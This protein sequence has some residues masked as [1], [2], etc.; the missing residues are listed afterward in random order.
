M[1][2]ALVALVLVPLGAEPAAAAQLVFTPSADAW[3]DSGQPA[4]SLGT[5]SSLWVDASPDTEQSFLRFEVAGIAGATVTDVRLRLYRKDASGPGGTV[6]LASGAWNETVT[7]NTRPQVSTALAPLSASVPQG[8]W[9]E[10]SLGPVISRDGTLDLA[11][12]TT[13]TDGAQWGAREGAFDPQLIVET[14][15]TVPVDTFAFGARADTFVDQANAATAYGASATLNVDGSP[16]KQTFLRFDLGEI[17]GRI[18]VSATLRLYTKNPSPL[19][20]R[21]Y[22]VVD[23]AWPESITWNTKPPIGDTS[24][25]TVGAVTTGTWA[26]AAL[27]PAALDDGVLS[28]A[29][30]SN[31]SDG[32]QYSSRN[33]ITNHPQLMVEVEEAGGPVDGLS[34]VAPSE[35]GSSDPTFFGETHRLAI[36][37]EGRLLTVH[38][39][40]ST[41]VQ[42]AWR[43]PSGGWQTATQG[44]VSNGLLLS[45]SGTGDWPASVVVGED[46]SGNEHAWVVYGAQG[47]SNRHPIRMRRLS[48]LDAPGGPSVGPVV[49]VASPTAEGGHARPDIAIEQT[50]SGPRVYVA[51]V[52]K[53]T[54]G[55]YDVRVLS[56]D[57]LDVDD[58]SASFSAPT[59]LLASGS[60]VRTVTLEPSPTGLSAVA[61]GNS[62]LLTHYLH[63]AANPPG[64]WSTAGTGAPLATVAH[65]SAVALDNGDVLAAAASSS[66]GSGN[67]VIVQRFAGGSGAAQAVE[68]TATGYREPTLATDG[69]NAWLV[70]VRAS[71]GDVVSRAYTP[72]GG[73]GGDVVEIDSAS[74]GGN[75]AW[76]NAL[77][78]ADE[79]LRFVVRGP[80]PGAAGGTQTSVLACQHVLS[81]TAEPACT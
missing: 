49:T 62:N 30:R 78:H 18:V 35:S 14:E 16:A 40:H 2:A 79:R 43:D 5:G 6:S 39:K 55:S 51:W 44:S 41:G 73:W 4:T 75:H 57:D 10:V 61:R 19:G 17:E 33:A 3:V 20:G 26:E 7:W 46:S 77:R 80:G 32:A 81:S 53:L 23:D 42:L 34:L 15:G 66:D 21:V 8:S 58:P 13:A 72:A 38:G 11:L 9:D 52:R 1:A 31:N 50:A 54:T 24:I 27:D 29:I 12:S 28:L 63:S 22:P 59:V 67:T 68:L 47:F 45:G 48:D 64:A 60:S 37:S 70:M 71:D 74:S 69:T 25:G 56:F 76:P 36:T 65:P